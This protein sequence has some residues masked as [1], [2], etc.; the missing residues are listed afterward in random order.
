MPE[1]YSDTFYIGYYK[2]KLC[3]KKSLVNMYITNIQQDWKK[4]EINTQIFR[5]HNKINKNRKF[6]FHN[7]I[8]FLREIHVFHT[9]KTLREKKFPFT[10]YRCF[11]GI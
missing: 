2:M 10:I 8:F 9:I 3:L 1:P 5:K 4:N 11:R 6:Q 7:I